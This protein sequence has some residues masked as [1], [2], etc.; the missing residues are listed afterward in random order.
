MTPLP[1]DRFARPW[2]VP[3]D[4][5]S[6]SV[7][8]SR[9]GEELH[10]VKSEFL[11]NVSHELRTPLSG[12]IG[13]I[14]LLEKSALTGEQR[15]YLELL[16]SSAETLAQLVNDLLDYSRADRG[17]YHLACELFSPVSVVEKA[18]AP[19]AVEAR[20]KGLALSLEQ[21]TAREL[22]VL[23]DPV[24]LRQIV[25]N[26]VMNAITYTERG[27]V[28]IS[29]RTLSSSSDGV[30][31]EI[32]VADTGIGIPSEKLGAI[33][34]S[35]IQLEGPYTKNHRG[36]G[37]GL[38][39]VRELVTAM[40]GTVSVESTVGLGSLFTVRLPLPQRALPDPRAG[41]AAEQADP[42]C[43]GGTILVAEDEAINRLYVKT[44]LSR[45]GYETSAAGTGLEVLSLL[46]RGHYDLILLDVGMPQLDG[47]ETARRIRA[48]EVT[49]GGHV[50]IIALTAHAYREDVRRC[51]D[52]G[53]DDCVI[54]PFSE[55]EL[56]AK[57]SNVLTL[58]R[59]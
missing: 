2:A 53:V 9:H 32:S 39:I 58:S 31:I 28:Q 51:M 42:V 43:P 29:E 46:A 50:P 12:V 10:V 56:L 41:A 30:T 1:F 36:L 26:L 21:E 35:F 52:A 48:A 38:A 8:D 20:A 47:V 27:S 45:Q 13:M 19:L 3:D 7:R 17:G 55:R 54:K 33:F 40:G 15:D 16:R 14:G 4:G 59:R 5:A 57:I 37:I 22:V 49:E 18:V 11:A 23:G 25:S 6:S 24:R 34:E 44:L